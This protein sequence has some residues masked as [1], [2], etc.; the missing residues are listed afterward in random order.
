MEDGLLVPNHLAVSDRQG[1]VAALQVKVLK[2]QLDYLDD[3]GDRA[4]T[5]VTATSLNP[6]DTR[7]R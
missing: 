6:C 7:R 5:T 2:C 3:G 1:V 4:K